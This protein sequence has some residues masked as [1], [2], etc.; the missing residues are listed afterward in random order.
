VIQE[1]SL[2]TRFALSSDVVHGGG[3]GHAMRL[4]SIITDIQME[5]GSGFTVLSKLL[6]LSKELSREKKDLSEVH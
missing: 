5:R 6:T 4:I 1:D 3:E 2:G